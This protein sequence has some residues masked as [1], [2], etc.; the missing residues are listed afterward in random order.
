NRQPI[1]RANRRLPIKSTL[2]L[3][4]SH[5]ALV[6]PYEKKSASQ[7]LLGL[8]EKAYTPQGYVAGFLGGD[9]RCIRPQFSL[10]WHSSCPY[11]VLRKFRT[12]LRIE[13]QYDR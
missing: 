2:C 6:K 8:R 3:C 1:D 7:D 13:M 5:T 12:I 4:F 10:F 9:P 11:T